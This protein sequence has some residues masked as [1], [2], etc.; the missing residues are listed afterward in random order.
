MSNQADDYIYLE[1]SSPGRRHYKVWYI[2]YNKNDD[3]FLLESP[4]SQKIIKLKNAEVFVKIFINDMNHYVYNNIEEET[5]SLRLYI[6]KELYSDYRCNY[7]KAI[8]NDVASQYI[9]ALKEIM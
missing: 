1:T 6:Q 3:Y 8:P 2:T 9:S 5:A 7:S 4:S